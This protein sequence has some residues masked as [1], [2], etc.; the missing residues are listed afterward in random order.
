MGL[1]VQTIRSKGR[2]AKD[3]TSGETVRSSSDHNWRNLCVPLCRVDLWVVGRKPPP[4]LFTLRTTLLRDKTHPSPSPIQRATIS[5]SFQLFP[6][7]GLP[8]GNSIIPTSPLRR[9]EITCNLYTTKRV[10][11]GKSKWGW[12][13]SR[14]IGM[15]IS[16]NIAV[17]FMAIEVLRRIVSRLLSIE[18]LKVS[19]NRFGKS[20][21]L[22]IF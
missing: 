21:V 9:R 3:A 22:F 16:W 13:F 19:W 10:F 17:C 15:R 14:R 12:T 2:G 18:G 7:V 1:R 6:K 8:T 4:W 20:M 11:C 5:T